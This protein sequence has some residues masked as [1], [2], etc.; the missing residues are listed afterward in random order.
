MTST[1]RDHEQ[2][3]DGWQGRPQILEDLLPAVSTSDKS[4]LICEIPTANS[5]SNPIVI[6]DDESYSPP[7]SSDLRK[8]ERLIDEPPSKR[9]RISGP[10]EIRDSLPA[11][12]D[13]T[14]NLTRQGPH[15]AYGHSISDYARQSDLQKSEMGTPAPDYI[16]IAST[17]SDDE[18]DSKSLDQVL[19]QSLSQMNPAPGLQLCKEQAD[20]ADTIM[21]GKNVFYTG[22]A[23]CGKSFVLKSFVRCLQDLG[24]RVVIVAPTGKAALN[25]NGSTYWS[26]AGWHPDVMR[27]PM[28]DLYATSHRKRTYK[29]FTE[30][31]VLVIDEISMMENFHFERLNRVM[32]EARIRS[33]HKPFGGVQIVVSGDFCQLPP[34]DPMKFCL[35]CG[36]QL[37]FLPGRRKRC[38]EH[39]DFMLED[40]WAFRSA[41]WRECNFVHVNLTTVHRQKDP[42]FKAMLEKIRLGKQL[43]YEEK[44]LL[45]NHESVTDGGVKLFSKVDAVRRI[46]EKNFNQLQ[47]P[48][49]KYQ[50]HD[51]FEMRDG[52]DDLVRFKKRND[53]DGSI[54][55]LS[56]HRLQ[57]KVELREGMLV[58]L[59]TNSN[60]TGGL[61]NGSQ[62]IITGFDSAAIPQD[63]SDP[64]GEH[65]VLR[66]TLLHDFVKANKAGKWPIV[67]FLNGTTAPIYPYCTVSEMG[68]Q[69]PWSLLSRTQIPLMAAWAITIH[70]AQGMT[71]ER[72]VVD[73]GDT[74]EEGHDYVALSR[75][76]CL[77]GLKVEN[78][79]RLDKGVNMQ[80][81]NFL[82][83]HF[84][85]LEKQ[86]PRL[87]LP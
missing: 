86:P 14:Q 39:G 20:L 76:T 32:K 62:G 84:G 79:G 77:Q 34:V 59:L 47:T 57:T 13:T 21:S 16:S 7:K 9:Q 38:V 87:S 65:S 30:T 44:E 55:A 71:L 48:I 66:K 60:V 69:K 40:Q 80:V 53:M 29:R 41:A 18:F 56:E 83:H 70:K 49:V 36:R 72:V 3:V 68:P 74:F 6:D 31:D 37:K 82:E 85:N 81:R 35:E 63:V 26:Y 67:R 1:A 73:L 19:S 64:K 75:A 52:H 45:K 25:V 51:Y 24:K 27:K 12:A 5:I 10:V 15:D 78:L 11:N 46:N 58:M 61:V 50:C 4:P 22:S 54:D 28:K 8:D 43:T 23:G 42:I 17:P 33:P 2:A